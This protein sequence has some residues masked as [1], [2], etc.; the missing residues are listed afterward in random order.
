MHQVV[1]GKFFANVGF[2]LRIPNHQA[3]HVR[4]RRRPGFAGAASGVYGL[5]FPG[6]MKVHCI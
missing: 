4:P 5:I 3:F 2:V 6:A 1:K